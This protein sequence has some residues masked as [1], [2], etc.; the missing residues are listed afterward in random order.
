[1]LKMNLPSLENVILQF[2]KLPG[3]GQKTAQRLAFSLLKMNQNEVKSFAE[4]LTDL[5]HNIR[6]CAQ[7]NYLAE[8]EFCEFCNNSRRRKKYICVVAEVTDVLAVERTND[9]NGLYHVLGGV[10]SPLDGVG[11]DKLNID[12]LMQRLE[13]VEEVILALPASTS[14]ESTS[15]Y[16]SR[17]VHQRGV[18][19]ISRI[20]RGIPMG[21]QLD[22]IDEVTM[23]RA[24]EGRSEL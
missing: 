16:L 22:F 5:H 19:K 9:Y 13:D 6:F 23:A 17:L 12:D 24:L 8:D 11:P 21:A 15:I 14:G 4:A 18:S 7:C 3:I 10:L 1:M 20:A 2:T